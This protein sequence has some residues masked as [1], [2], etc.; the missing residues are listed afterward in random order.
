MLDVHFPCDYPFRPPKVHFATKIYHPNI[1]SLGNIS[2]N[3][4][5]EQWCPAL[6]ISK[7]LLSICA[8]LP[9]PLLDEDP[10]MPEI[11]RTYVTNRLKFCLTASE[12]TRQYA[13]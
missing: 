9:D 8:L 1:D 13:M 7:V 4:L 2:V 3:I 10:L 6:T 12:W 11:A 5:K